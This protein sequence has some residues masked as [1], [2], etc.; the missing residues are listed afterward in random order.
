M[1]DIASSLAIPFLKM[2]DSAVARRVS[3]IKTYQS[4]PIYFIVEEC[5]QDPTWNVNEVV[6]HCQSN[7][8][9]EKIESLLK[10]KQVSACED[11]IEAGLSMVTTLLLPVNRRIAEKTNVVR[12]HIIAPSA[13]ETRRPLE[14]FTY[15]DCSHKISRGGRDTPGSGNRMEMRIILNVPLLSHS[16]ITI[17]IRRFLRTGLI[18]LIK[19]LS[20]EIEL[21]G[22]E[23]I[24]YTVQ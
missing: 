20:H 14:R 10:S 15:F 2:N 17:A 13:G 22:H 6:Y 18:K 12:F 16:C 3:D 9:L 23:I 21:I 1:A 8:I 4:P 19:I 7:D 11:E 5:V 24:D